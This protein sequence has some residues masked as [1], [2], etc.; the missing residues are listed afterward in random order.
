MTAM[1]TQ[2]PG[3]LW[4][5]KPLAEAPASSTQDVSPLGTF[6]PR[7]CVVA[8]VDERGDAERALAAALWE[9]FE[10]DD[11]RLVPAR[12]AVAGSW[13]LRWRKASRPKRAIAAVVRLL[14]IEGE[15]QEAYLAAACR[16]SRLLIIR[17]RLRGDVEQARKLLLAGG[18]YNLSY[19]DA[20]GTV[21]ALGG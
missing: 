10:P 8:V 19:Y 16:G 12:E 5:R 3:A 9:G 2:L 18:A 17:A 15:A 21:E 14:A 20:A 7:Q 4:L 11:V 6:M 13:A 1:H